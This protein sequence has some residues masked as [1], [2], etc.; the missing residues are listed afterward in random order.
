MRNRQE[1]THHPTQASILHST[2]ATLGCLRLG[3][4]GVLITVI[5]PKVGVGDE[6]TMVN[7]P[8][9]GIGGVFF[10]RVTCLAPVIRVRLSLGN[11]LL[12]EMSLSFLGLAHGRNACQ[13]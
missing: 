8:K 7:L 4:G 5:P 2:V 3:V 6:K 9:V 13:G 12:V 1:F 11:N 10:P